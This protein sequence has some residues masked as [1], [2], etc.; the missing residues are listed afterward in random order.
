MLWEGVEVRVDLFVDMFDKVMIAC[1]WAT[2][3]WFR[4][5]KTIVLTSLGLCRGRDPFGKRSF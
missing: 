2:A 5:S 1:G 4:D 3:A